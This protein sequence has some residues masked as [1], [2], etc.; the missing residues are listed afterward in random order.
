M[1]QEAVCNRGWLSREQFLDLLAAT[2]L[3]PGPNATEMAIHI[4]FL[5]AGW[6]GLI[7]GGVAF[8]VPALWSAV[9]AGCPSG[10]SWTPWP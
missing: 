1:E 2:N 6:P 10:S 5:Q 4:G 3:V 9:S 7:A 8:I